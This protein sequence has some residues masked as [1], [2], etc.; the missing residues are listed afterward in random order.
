MLFLA[1][2]THVGAIAPVEDT[3]VLASQDKLQLKF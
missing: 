2:A 1:T 3:D